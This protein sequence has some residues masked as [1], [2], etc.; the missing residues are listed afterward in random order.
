MGIGEPQEGASSDWSIRSSSTLRGWVASWSLGQV[1]SEN[2]NLPFWPEETQPVSWW[3]LIMVID[4]AIIPRTLVTYQARALVHPLKS[5][6]TPG[7]V[8]HGAHFTDKWAGPSLPPIWPRSDRHTINPSTHLLTQR[9]LI[10]RTHYM[11]GIVVSATD[12]NIDK[13]LWA[14]AFMERES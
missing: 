6:N 4:P 7:W 12:Y 5:P 3:Q 2:L 11:P 13:L 10:E 1:T 14:P 8:G 9:M